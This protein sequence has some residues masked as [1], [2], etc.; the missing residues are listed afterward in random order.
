MIIG[1][2]IG[3]LHLT[4]AERDGSVTLRLLM[5]DKPTSRRAAQLLTAWTARQVALLR[6]ATAAAAGRNV[7]AG[8]GQLAPASTEARVGRTLAAA[9]CDSEETGVALAAC[10]IESAFEGAV[11]W[12]SPMT[13]GFCIP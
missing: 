13:S 5:R 12:V 6:E 4:Q 11:E 1:K 2:D 7:E 10:S 8:G 3:L 9:V